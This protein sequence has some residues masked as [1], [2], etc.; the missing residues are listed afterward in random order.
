MHRFAFC[1]WTS[2]IFEVIV[3]GF[4]C[5]FFFSSCVL[6]NFVFLCMHGFV[7]TIDMCV[8]LSMYIQW[9]LQ[10]CCID[11]HLCTYMCMCSGGFRLI[12]CCFLIY[13]VLH[14]FFCFCFASYCCNCIAVSVHVCLWEKTLPLSFVRPIAI[15]VSTCTG[16]IGF[17]ISC[18]DIPQAWRK[19][20]RNVSALLLA[21]ACLV[22][23]HSLTC[24]IPCVPR[25]VSLR[26][27]GNWPVGRGSQLHGRGSLAPNVCVILVRAV[28]LVKFKKKPLSIP[29]WW[30]DSPICG[31]NSSCNSMQKAQQAC[32]SSLCV[33]HMQVHCSV[34]GS[35]SLCSYYIIFL[36]ILY[37]RNISCHYFPS[38]TSP[39]DLL[40]STSQRC[41]EPSSRSLFSE[42]WFLGWHA[43][44]DVHE[45]L[46]EG[47]ISCVF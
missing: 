40:S 45:K 14:L 31:W 9:D 10:F 35:L 32:S 21:E 46:P 37:K 33:A 2:F 29:G 19:A 3:Q 26:R 22:S 41:L 17:L 36:L 1:F 38:T 30:W 12:F 16:C 13:S 18:L 44:W 23:A 47:H 42:G 25:V 20:S 39:S 28:V 5:S 6:R 4:F 24:C 34:H 43:L 8:F 11:K 27:F 15:H 7:D